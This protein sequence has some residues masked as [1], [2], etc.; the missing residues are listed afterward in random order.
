MLQTEFAWFLISRNKKTNLRAFLES[1]KGT[2]MTD[3]EALAFDFEKL[4]GKP[5]TLIVAHKP[6]SKGGGMK[7]AIVGISPAK[8]APPAVNPLV[9]YEIDIREGGTFN[10]L[11][12]FLQAKLRESDEFRGV[13]QGNEGPDDHAA[14]EGEPDWGAETGTEIVGEGGEGW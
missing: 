10:K 1:W 13:T 3:D 4:L 2:E 7:A 5:C 11:P 9:C 12:P 6:K 8:S 14:G